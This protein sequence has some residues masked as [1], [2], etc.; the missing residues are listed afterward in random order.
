M[1]KNNIIYFIL[2]I[3]LGLILYLFNQASMAELADTE[4]QQIRLPLTAPLTTFNPSQATIES[5]LQLTAYLFSGLTQLNPETYQIEPALAQRWSI[6]N[7][8][9]HYI[10]HLRPQLRWNNGEPIT[11]QDMVDTLHFHLKPENKMPFVHWLYPLKN[12]QAI[13]Q[14]ELEDFTQLGVRALDQET[15]M[16]TLMQPTPYFLTLTSLMPYMPLPAVL[17]KTEAT[18]LNDIKQLPTSGPY[19]LSHIAEGVINLTPNNNFFNPMQAKIPHLTLQW[20]NPEIDLMILA[21]TNTNTDQSMSYSLTQHY[22]PQF[23]TVS[24]LFNIQKFP[25]DQALIRKAISASIDR[26]L[27]L[28]LLN[29]PHS[30]AFHFTPPLLLGETEKIPEPFGISF[31]PEAAQLWLDKVN[32]E[33]QLEDKWPVITLLLPDEAESI[34][35]AETIAHSLKYHLNLTLELKPYAT[36]D[37]LQHIAQ[38]NWESDLLQLTWCGDYPD[39]HSWLYDVLNTALLS[40]LMTDKYTNII[41]LMQRSLSLSASPQR[42]E[43]YQYA[44]HFLIEQEAIFLPLYFLN[45]RYYMDS[46]LKMAHLNPFN[47]SWW[48]Q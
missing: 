29:K 30:P 13:H 31:D 22:I 47:G 7:N 46:V 15:L 23:C 20:V 2:C 19:Q 48:I 11:A 1:K 5:D 25:M 44:E 40:P 39:A 16:F 18:P 26:Q 24:Y 8:G 36:A 38:G 34:K 14:G 35:I 4:L 42:Y 12:A 21:K 27:A 43:L 37:Y 17:L 6:S 45:H 32:T 33:L 3:L 10:F 28:D 41:A 9:L